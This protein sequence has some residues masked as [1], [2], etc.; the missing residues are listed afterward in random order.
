MEKSDIIEH[1]HP[2]LQ[3]REFEEIFLK[4]AHSNGLLAIR[5]YPPAK[6]TG[7][8]RFTV[9]KGQLDYEVV[10]CGGKWGAIDCKSFIDDFFTYSVLCQEQI[11]TAVLY[12]DWKI[13]SGFVVWLRKPNQVVFYSGRTIQS[14]GPGGRFEAKDGFVL[15][16]IED[17]DLRKL[18]KTITGKRP[19]SSISSGT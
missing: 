7:N 4:R 1:V 16:T 12:N 3:G 11:K 19:L 18:W 10:T 14:I 9:L 15:G 2:Q 6:P 13:L 5:K 17:F 8:G